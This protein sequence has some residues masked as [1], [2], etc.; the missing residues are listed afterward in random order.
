MESSNLDEVTKTK[1][2]LIATRP[3]T[4][5]VG[6]SPIVIAAGLAVNQGIFVLGI[7]IVSLVA[8]LLNQ[9]GTHFVNDYYDAIRGI[10]TD[11]REGFTRVTQ[12]GLLPADHVKQGIW[13]VYGLT[14][15]AGIYPVYVGGLP[16]LVTGILLAAVGFL[17]AG[18]PVYYA[19]NGLGDVAI[20][21]DFGVVP[22]VATYYLM[23]VYQSGVGPFPVEIPAGTITAEALVASLAPAGLATGMMIINNMRDRETDAEAGKRT[24]PVRFGYFWSRVEFVAMIGLAYVAP[25]TLWAGYGFDTWVLLPLLSLPYAASVTHQVLTNTDKVLN[26]A[27]VREGHLTSLFSVLFAVGL[28]VPAVL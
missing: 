5:P 23:A 2:W 8:M 1:A 16:M 28:S 4:V 20:F 14:V 3:M 24:I 10:D 9:Q 26:R 13:V 18:P 21:F 11:D 7:G 19:D 25:I 27:L 6:V 22:A 17:Y 12:A 15:L